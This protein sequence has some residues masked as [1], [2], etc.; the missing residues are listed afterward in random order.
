ML[1]MS[2]LKSDQ[3]KLSPSS[4]IDL[5]IFAN[6]EQEPPEECTDFKLCIALQRLL[7]ALRYYT[8]LNICTNNDH[9]NIFLNFTNE[10][11]KHPLLVQDFY[12]F[13]K[14]HNQQIYQI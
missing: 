12:H 7:C 11:Y 10:V 5:S 13:Q 14:Q 4:V 2:S 3:S 9:Q 1:T 8:S 6:T